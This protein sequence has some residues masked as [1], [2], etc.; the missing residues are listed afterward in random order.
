MQSI[1]DYSGRRVHYFSSLRWPAGHGRCSPKLGSHRM[2][3]PSEETDRRSPEGSTGTRRKEPSLCHLVCYRFRCSNDKAKDI[4]DKCGEVGGAL[5]RYAKNFGITQAAIGVLY[6]LS[7]A[8]QFSESGNVPWKCFLAGSI[9]S[10]SQL[11]VLSFPWRFGSSF[12]L[13]RLTD[14]LSTQCRRCLIGLMPGRTRGVAKSVCCS[15]VGRT[16]N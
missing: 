10:R 14:T 6:L 5:E 11:S 12:Q 16:E 4:E 9:L 7:L 1:G 2:F 13:T 8:P 15:R 3:G